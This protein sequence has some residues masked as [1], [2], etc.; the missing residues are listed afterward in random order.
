MNS[1][2]ENKKKLHDF[3]G[4][5]YQS[6]KVYVRSKIKTSVNREA[7]DIIQDVALKL[8]A[9]ADRY[10]PINNVAG[11]VYYAIKNKIIDVMRSNN[12]SELPTENENELKLIEF[13]EL[14][15]GSSDNSYPEQ[16]K[17]DLKHAILNLKPNYRD[18]IIAIDF[19]GYTYKEISY[20]TDIPIGTLMS[21][22]HRAIA[23]LHKTVTTK[24]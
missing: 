23:L 6:L 16:M 20:E 18:I 4:T 8:F 11:F 17:I 5:E 10:S 9:G 22:R 19:E 7:E 15:Y 21:R 24:K 14:L 3:F 12:K 1:E 13:A 2:S